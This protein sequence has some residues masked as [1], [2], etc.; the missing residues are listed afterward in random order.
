MNNKI[1][2]DDIVREVIRIDALEATNI[3]ARSDDG[4]DY[5]EAWITLCEMVVD[6]DY[7]SEV[8]KCFELDR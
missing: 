7:K 5:Q 4:V 2:D 3:L 1:N 6:E 8:L